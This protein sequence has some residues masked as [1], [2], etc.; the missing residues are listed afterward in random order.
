MIINI[1]F[2]RNNFNLNIND[3]VNTI[4]SLIHKLLGNNNQYHDTFSDYSVSSVQGV[5]LRNGMLIPKGNSSPFIQIASNSPTFLFTVD[6]SIENFDNDAFNCI[7]IDKTATYNSSYRDFLTQKFFDKVISI[8][9][10]LLKQNGKYITPI[11]DSELWLSLLTEQCADKLKKSGIENPTIKISYRGID[12][13]KVQKVWIDKSKK[14][15]AIGTMIGL[16]IEG[17]QNER[18]MLYNMGLGCSTGSQFGAVKLYD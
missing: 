1:V 10:I 6:K 14:C 2:D 16:K 12:K 7:K 5:V 4:N 8:S 13:C 18:N 17:K 15:F 9:P 3:S 11:N